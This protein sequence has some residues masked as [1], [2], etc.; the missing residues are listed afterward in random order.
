[1]TPDDKKADRILDAALPVFVRFGFR[2]T[3]MGDLAKAA[4]I[5]RA[6]L[7]LS[8][9]SKEDVF[10][11]GSMRAHSRALEKVEKVLAGSEDVFVRIEKAL[12]A[13]HEDLIAPFGESDDPQELF[14]ANMVL[15]KDV[16]MHARR[17]LV[18]LLGRALAVADASG[19]VSLKKTGATA[20][21]LADM[22]IAAI[23]GLKHAQGI[24]AE[25]ER[26]TRLFL[27]IMRSALSP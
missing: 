6:S 11:A 19:E 18:A 15:A 14:D 13:F 8:F 9:K 16:T 17:R 22:T 25:L 5:S 1:M 4:R 21:E 23:D 3:S 26:A 20:E 10:R 24:N 7:Y 12:T 2:K 27:G